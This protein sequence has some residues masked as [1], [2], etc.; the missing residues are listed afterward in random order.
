[1]M[2][3]VIRVPLAPIRAQ[4]DDR[5][6]LVTQSLFGE[7]VEVHPVQG[8]PLWVKVRLNQDGYEGYMDAPHGRI[9]P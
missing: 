8:L 9:G 3:G 5:A 6:E 7:L 4:A 1:M 2:Q